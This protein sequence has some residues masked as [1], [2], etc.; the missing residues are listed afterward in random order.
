MKCIHCGKDSKLKERG[1][2]RCKHCQRPFAFEPT[3][4]K[5]LTVTD[6]GFQAAIA[7]V[8]ERGR[9]AFTP[10]QLYYQA[11]RPQARKEQG[12]KRSAVGGLALAGIAGVFV[13]CACGPV[14]RVLPLWGAAL[15]AGGLITLAVLVWALVGPVAQRLP[16]PASVPPLD[17]A[18]FRQDYLAR[19][20]RAH[21][22][23]ARLLP[24]TERARASG[25]GQAFAEELQGYSFDRLLVCDRAETA[26]FL[27]ANNL[28]TETNTPIVSVDGYPQGV[29]ERVLAMVRRNPKLVVFA[30]H[31]ADAAGCLLPLRLREEARW[32]P[33]SGVAIV[34][35]GLRPRQVATS[36]NAIVSVQRGG[37]ATLPPGLERVLTHGERAWL[38]TGHRAE[39]A[40]VP[41]ARLLQV[42][43]RAFTQS[44]AEVER[45]RAAAGRDPRGFFR[46]AVRVM[47]NE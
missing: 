47:S 21:G 15:L 30:L 16:R 4:Q 40:A 42:V 22:P 25:A 41:P 45:Q 32:F 10:R 14:L 17:L 27:I 20:E 11:L 33:Q 12:R 28:H 29:F 24:D 13:F 23:V 9:L 3:T 7:A 34:D 26:E 5:G 44:A 6:P 38:A 36:G 2:G 43:Y 31:D 46:T 1:G 39:L 19:W 8:S 37:A 35:I 18:H